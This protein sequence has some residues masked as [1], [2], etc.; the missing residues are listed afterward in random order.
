M[1]WVKFV[2]KAKRTEPNERAAAVAG[3]LQSQS[4]FRTLLTY[5]RLTKWRTRANQVPMLIK[6]KTFVG[7]D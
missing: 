4:S 3:R 7:E 5:L 2:C 6:T 1:D